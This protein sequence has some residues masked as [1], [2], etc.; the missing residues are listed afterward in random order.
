MV[1]E[2]KCSL[3]CTVSGEGRRPVNVRVL[4]IQLVYNALM[5]NPMP[6]NRR[7]TLKSQSSVVYVNKLS[8][9]GDNFTVDIHSFTNEVAVDCQCGS[10]AYIIS[11][12]HSVSVSC[13]V[14]LCSIQEPIRCTKTTCSA[15]EADCCIVGNNDDIA[16]DTCIYVSKNELTFLSTQRI[17]QLRETSNQFQAVNHNFVHSTV[18]AACRN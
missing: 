7:P 13:R 4:E 15:C 5:Q 18:L 3:M 10:F 9:G 11:G 17:I 6:N 8:L 2:F 12:A 14:Y 1:E 16:A